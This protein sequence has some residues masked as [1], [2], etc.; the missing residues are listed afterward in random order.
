[1]LRFEREVVGAIGLLVLIWVDRVPVPRSLHRLVAALAGASLY[2]YLV[3]WEV[4]PLVHRT[5]KVLAFVVSMAVGYAVWVVARRV[6]AA[7][8]ARIARRPPG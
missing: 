5:S 2:I 8:E 1:M 4:F 7:V 3:H 6:S